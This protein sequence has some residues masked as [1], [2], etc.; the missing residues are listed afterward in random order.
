MELHDLFPQSEDGRHFAKPEKRPISAA[1]ILRV[2][3]FEAS[4]VAVAAAD[5]AAG[6]PLA[7]GDKARLTKAVVYIDAALAAGGIR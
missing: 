6:K 3:A 1:D 7:D 4:L 5:M 2:I